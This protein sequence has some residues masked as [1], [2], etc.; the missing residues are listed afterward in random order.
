MARVKI[1]LPNTFIFSTDVKIRIGD[2][3]YGGHVGNDA[4]LSLIHTA[5]IEFLNKLG[6]S[7]L[8]IEGIGIIMTDSAI[9]YKGESFFGDIIEIKLGVLDFSKFGFDIVYSLSHKESKKEIAYAKTGI[10]GFNYEKRKIA[11][12][13]EKALLKFK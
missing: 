3:N 7:E 9:V 10:V 1:E 13:P 2:I 8:D 5:R 11:P 4:I 12:I 6:Y